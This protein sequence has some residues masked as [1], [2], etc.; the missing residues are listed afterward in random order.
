[1]EMK[2]E[3]SNADPGNKPSKNLPL[4][5][6]IIREK[7]RASKDEISTQKLLEIKIEKTRWDTIVQGLQALSSFA[8]VVVTV[9]I[10]IFAYKQWDAATQQADAAKKQAVAATKQVDAA[11]EQIKV[12]KAQ[13]ELVSKQAVAAKKQADAANEQIKVAKAQNELMMR[14]NEEGKKSNLNVNP[15][16]V[17]Y[18]I[19]GSG[20]DKDKIDM[21]FKNLSSRPTAILSIDFTTKEGSIFRTIGESDGIE[22]PLNIGAWRAE[23]ISFDLKKGDIEQ[24]KDILV[25][26]LD[27]K[28]I[29]AEQRR[30]AY[31]TIGDGI[32]MK[33]MLGSTVSSTT[34]TVKV[35][36]NQT[37]TRSGITIFV[38]SIKFETQSGRFV[39]NVTISAPGK[40]YKKVSSDKIN[41]C[42][43]YDEYAIRLHSILSDC[44]EFIISY[45]ENTCE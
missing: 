14:I 15:V 41:T 28:Q 31:L 17:T 12:A 8:M 10:A 40:K 20:H 3:D 6:E 4:G 16:N 21:V 22:L 45:N 34:N 2:K 32:S 42:W 19:G 25:T 13:N 11:N 36:K 30:H 27:N 24:L 44:A 33:A 18:H 1:M 29:P 26:D 43:T 37:V 38:E 9:F 39:I 23:K 7:Y 5:E 35:C